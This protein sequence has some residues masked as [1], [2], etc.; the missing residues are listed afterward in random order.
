[1]HRR[2]LVKRTR[3]KNK[4]VSA[5]EMRVGSGKSLRRIIAHAEILDALY[6]HVCCCFLLYSAGIQLLH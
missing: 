2:S 1:M 5:A 4:L 6:C 3:D